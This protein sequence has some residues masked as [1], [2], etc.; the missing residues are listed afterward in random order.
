M[1]NDEWLMIN[2]LKMIRK[3]VSFDVLAASNRIYRRFKI[4]LL[5]LQTF[6]T[7]GQATRQ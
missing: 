2:E 1:S 3:E 4:M 5:N 6:K 7:N